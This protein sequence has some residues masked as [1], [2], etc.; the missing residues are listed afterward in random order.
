MQ[1]SFNGKGL[2]NIDGSWSGITNS[3]KKFINENLTPTNSKLV[4][5][6]RKLK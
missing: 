6:C 2:R 5:H 3:N 1:K 4:F